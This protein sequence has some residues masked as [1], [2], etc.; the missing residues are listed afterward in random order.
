[1]RLR[2]FLIARR[3]SDP[4]WM[5]PPIPLASALTERGSMPLWLDK[6]SG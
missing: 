3:R 6:I 1:V 4:G 5:D 2:S